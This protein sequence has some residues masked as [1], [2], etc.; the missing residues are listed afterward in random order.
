[1]YHIWLSHDLAVLAGVLIW[2]FPDRRRSKLPLNDL[3]QRGVCFLWEEKEFAGRHE[4]GCCVSERILAGMQM[5]DH[6]HGKVRVC[7]KR[8]KP[9]TYIHARAHVSSTGPVPLD[10]DFI[11]AVID[12]GS[13]SV[14][15]CSLFALSVV[16]RAMVIW[17]WRCACGGKCTGSTAS[18]HQSLTLPPALYPR[19]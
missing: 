8:K 3:T 19:P 1:M 12:D 16:E 18:P 9:L 17:R 14:Q 2:N 15:V 6:A 11:I 7:I 5:I 13:P 4:S 10:E